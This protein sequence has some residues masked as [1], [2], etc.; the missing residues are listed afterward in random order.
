MKSILLLGGAA[1]VLSAC[2]GV[3]GATDQAGISRSTVGLCSE[4][5]RDVLNNRA[6]D[7]D[8]KDRLKEAGI[9]CLVAGANDVLTVDPKPA[10]PGE[11]GELVAANAEAAAALN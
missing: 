11:A 4:L 1:I 2:Q 10:T 9:M 5:L 7:E 6:P 3:L 8:I